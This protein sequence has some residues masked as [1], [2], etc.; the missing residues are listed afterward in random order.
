VRH[1]QRAG[2]ALQAT[3]TVKLCLSAQATA[4]LLLGFTGLLLL[5]LGWNS[6]IAGGVPAWDFAADMLLGNR[7]RDEGML[8]VG[9]YSRYEFNH[10]GPFWFYYNYLFELGLERSGLSRTHIWLFGQTIMATLLLGF[11]GGGLS[12]FL[13]GKLRFWP[14]TLT[15]F[16]LCGYLGADLVSLWMPHRLIAP[17]LA[18]M[19]CC[20]LLI[21]GRIRLLP[22]ATLLTCVLIHGY[23]TMPLFTLL[24]LT[25]A[26]LLGWRVRQ[27]TGISRAAI[28]ASM[29]A[30]ALIAGVFVLPIAYDALYVS[31][32]NLSKLLYAQHGFSFLPKPNWLEMLSFI[33]SL[34]PPDGFW[35]ALGIGITTLLALR[36]RYS[37]VRPAL[38]ASA[39]LLGTVL[40]LVLYY[41]RTP[42][43]LY[44]FVALFS[45]GIAPLLL[46]VVLM[47]ALN[48]TL[49]RFN[50]SLPIQALA[51]F[52][53]FFLVYLLAPFKQSPEQV[54]QKSNE[55]SEFA[56]FMRRDLPPEQMAS[57][58]YSNH[59]LWPFMAGLLLE[60][61]RQGM[62]ACTT[63]RHMGFLYTDAETCLPEMRPQ[64]R[65]V[66][67]DQCE[68]LCLFNTFDHG[69]RPI[70]LQALSIAQPYDHNSQQLPFQNW[71]PAEPLY[72]WSSGNSS[73]I[74]FALDKQ[75]PRPY[76]L[77][78]SVSSF[79]SQ[80]VEIFLNEQPVY[81]SEL[82]GTE[83]TLKIPLSSGIIYTGNNNLRFV[84]P[85][86]QQP[87]TA[88]PR[89]LALA[90]KNLQ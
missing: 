1:P 62:K 11:T 22:L 35:L 5:S 6:L 9:H 84:L 56:E 83:T 78:I 85:D 33:R 14:A 54:E 23:A 53:C 8:L 12:L 19:V 57:I 59:D 40:L 52:A 39:L 68:G 58:D 41:K 45:T 29:T 88:D 17:Y 87:Q 3:V 13:F 64:Y 81:T 20:L 2:A 37:V 48:E 70:R 43:P 10:P 50:Q 63:W 76:E 75:E 36:P 46:A 65:V 21:Q 28:T 18:F 74:T 7:I 77:L 16:T 72:R 90:F 82:S 27:K 47:S 60:L 30:S 51:V 89:L 15:V 71:Y 34:L 55:F 32:S 66:P 73:S 79:G 86:A 4:L 25:V 38:Q 61:D 42:A 49:S 69:L 44:D 26:L 31:P 80:S 67:A 24:P